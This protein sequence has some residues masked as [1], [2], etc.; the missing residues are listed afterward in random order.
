M[1]NKWYEIPVRI[2]RKGL[3]LVVPANQVQD[4]DKVWLVFGTSHISSGCIADDDEE[5][6][7]IQLNGGLDCWPAEMFINK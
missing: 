1:K 2:E 3:I 4:G 6:M 7:Y 5:I